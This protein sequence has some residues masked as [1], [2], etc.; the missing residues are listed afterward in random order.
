MALDRE[1]AVLRARGA[2]DAQVQQALPQLRTLAEEWWIQRTLAANEARR[3]GIKISEAEYTDAVQ[4][5]AR[6]GETMNEILARGGGENFVRR[7]FTDDLRVAKLL[8][9]VADKVPDPTEQEIETFYEEQKAQLVHPEAVEVARI[10]VA[11]AE[12]ESAELRAQ[13]KAKAEQIRSVI[14]S[15]KASFEAMAKANSD[16]PSK[17]R[18]GR[19]GDVVKG[20]AGP[21][22]DALCMLKTNEVSPVF[23]TPEGFQLFKVIAR[24][25]SRPIAYAEV[26]GELKTLLLQQHRQKAMDQFMRDLRAKAKI[27]RTPPPVAGSTP[28]KR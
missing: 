4:K 16:C 22:G 7:S 19:I 23:E 28:V 21:V 5:Q 1:V 20:R 17:D 6:P 13:K 8:Q 24:K 12:S 15:G 3:R 9:Q 26:K 14:M 11:A 25:E 2:T 10:L 18:G 27:K